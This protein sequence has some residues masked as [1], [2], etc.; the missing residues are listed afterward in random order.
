MKN[1]SYRLLALVVF[2]LIIISGCTK[3]G[4]SLTNLN[5]TATKYSLVAGHLD[6]LA[7]TGTVA[8]DSVRWVV[9]PA[10]Y[11][12]RQHGYNGYILSF[13]QAATYHVTAIVNGTDSASVN[14]VVSAAP[15]VTGGG[16]GGYTL[17]PLTGD[18][19]VLL[20]NFYQS[21]AKDTSYVYL[22]A[23]STNKYSCSN[24]TLAYNFNFTG[25]NFNLNFTGVNIPNGLGCTIGSGNTIATPIIMFR[26]PSSYAMP[27]G[28][29]NLIVGLNGTTY[30]GTVVVTSTTVTYNWPYTSG[31]TV[32]RT[33]I[34]R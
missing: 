14:I 4:V 9:T 25:S 10:F 24:S 34:N 28:T 17:T 21:A 32:S 2:A 6:S 31:V 27:N 22:T 18:Q 30:T 20:T 15:P 12:P 23:Q 11:A 19:I 33:V 8:T 26:S 7:L 29:Y 5:L 3:P 13:S 16:S 1:L